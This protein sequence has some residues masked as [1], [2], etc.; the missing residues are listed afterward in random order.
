M[1]SVA[2]DH[3]TRVVVAY[4]PGRQKKT[5]PNT[6]YCQH[7]TE[8]NVPGLDFTPYQLFLND[9]S[10]QLCTWRAAGERILLLIDA[11]EPILSGPLASQY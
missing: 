8:I 2:T 11:N 5:G 6:V 9:L 1:F 3:V 7:L 4:Y 10:R